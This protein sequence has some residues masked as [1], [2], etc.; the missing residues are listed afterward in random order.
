[1]NFMH[2]FRYHDI[3]DAVCGIEQ[4]PLRYRRTEAFLI[5]AKCS[6]RRR[7]KRKS[8]IFANFFFDKRRP[9]VDQIHNELN[10]SNAVL[11]MCIAIFKKPISRRT[12]SKICNKTT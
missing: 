12:G 5:N 9:N 2:Y 1:M 7:F 8:A 4:N 3:H 11:R 10:R 6:K